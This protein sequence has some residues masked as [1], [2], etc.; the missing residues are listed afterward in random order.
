LA[1]GEDS[2][3]VSQSVYFS[4]IN[5]NDGKTREEREKTGDMDELK[6]AS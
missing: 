3:S 6:V 2:K 1:A 5:L 4:R